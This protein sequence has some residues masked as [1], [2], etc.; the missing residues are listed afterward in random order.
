M[1]YFIRITLDGCPGS[2][3]HLI[4]HDSAVQRPASAGRRLHHGGGHWTLRK[5]CLCLL[6]PQLSISIVLTPE[7]QSRYSSL[8]C[9][10]GIALLESVEVSRLGSA[11][12]WG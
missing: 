6:H 8:Q 9:M 3:Q 2:F 5:P 11:A 7:K 1:Q 10:F 4:D 12:V